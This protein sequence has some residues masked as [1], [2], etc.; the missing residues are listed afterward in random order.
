LRRVRFGRG[1]SDRR[2]GRRP[3]AAGEPP[4]VL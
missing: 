4:P 3:V 1:L 2:A